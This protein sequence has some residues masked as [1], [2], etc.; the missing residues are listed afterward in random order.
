MQTLL[1]HDWPGNIRELENVMRK[2]LVLR[3]S[4]LVCEELQR[5]RRKASFESPA[6]AA[7]VASER[8][9][10]ESA[11][12]A[13]PASLDSDGET[14]PLD[15]ETAPMLERVDQAKKSAEVTVILSALNK[16]RWNR[17]QAADL[18]K[19]DYKALLYKMKKLQISA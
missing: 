10:I 8:R 17:R 4:D 12:P 16:T 15:S 13:I 18:L 3:D 9:Q 1:T 14:A 19:I 6:L 2:L 11:D 5:T 7:P